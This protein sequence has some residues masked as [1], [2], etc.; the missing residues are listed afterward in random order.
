MRRGLVL[1]VLLACLAAA[2]PATAHTASTSEPVPSLEPR[3][4]QQLYARLRDRQVF[5]TYRVSADCRPLRASTPAWYQDDPVD[6]THFCH[7][8]RWISARAWNCGPRARMR[9][10]WPGLARVF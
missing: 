1:A 3:A 9:V 7:E 5:R 10:A 2:V 4:T 8:V 6:M